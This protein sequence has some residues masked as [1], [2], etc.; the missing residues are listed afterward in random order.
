[1]K[2]RPEFKAC[3][4]NLEIVQIRLSPKPGLNAI[5]PMGRKHPGASTLIGFGF[6]KTHE[7]NE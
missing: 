7:N 2:E 5:L 3:V 6:Y 1:M 4:F